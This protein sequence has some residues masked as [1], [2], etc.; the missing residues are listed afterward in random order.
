MIEYTEQQQILL[1][2]VISNRKEQET[3]NRQIQFVVLGTDGYLH[4]NKINCY[5]Y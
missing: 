5:D 1:L 2:R 4:H 3:T